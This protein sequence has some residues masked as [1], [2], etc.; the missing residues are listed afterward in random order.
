MHCKD[1][2]LISAAGLMVW[3]SLC[4]PARVVGAE[5]PV[6][7]TPSVREGLDSVTRGGTETGASGSAPSVSIA[8]VENGKLAYQ[9]AAGMTN[10]GEKHTATSTTRYRI[11]S[12]TK[13]FTAVAV[14]QL[15]EQGKV[16]LDDKLSHYLPKAPHADEVTIR[17]LLMHTSGILN[18]M[19]AALANGSASK[20]ASPEELVGTVAK[21]PLDFA[22]GAHYEYSNTG[23]VLLGMVVQH[24][25]SMP[26]SVYIQRNIL[27]PAQMKETTFGLASQDA[28]VAV[29]YDDSTGKPALSVDPSWAFA[30]GDM[31]STAADLARFDIALMDGKLLK[32]ETLAL[33]QSDPVATGAG[34]STYGLGLEIFPFADKTFVGHHG[35]LPGFESDNEM[36][37]GDRFAIVV[38][39]NSTHFQTSR[40]IGR[41]LAVLLPATTSS[42]TATASKAANSPSVPAAG[43]DTAV[44]ALLQRFVADFRRGTVDRSIL[45]STMND[46]L[47]PQALSSA[48]SQLGPLGALQSAVYRGKSFV[49]GYVVYKYEGNF[50]SER[51]PITFTL[52]KDGKIAGLFFK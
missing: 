25:S 52:D 32:P 46:A 7:I 1:A 13:M 28:P 22:P 48:A 47:T 10:I 34:K 51:L 16:K 15:V 45:T 38:L 24:V 37:M 49:N 41:L 39:G 17:Q 3:M 4:M 30:A 6:A 8:I 36:T 12:I 33:M 20:A 29:G 44:T 26:L 40:V 23:Y 11:G 19:D 18:Y 27:E 9:N 43:E 14:M 5:T 50:A 42:E 21:E 35:G 2:G 31:L